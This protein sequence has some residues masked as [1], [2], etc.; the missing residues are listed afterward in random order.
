MAVSRT[1]SGSRMLSVLEQVAAHQPVSLA[2]LTRILRED[3]SAIQRSLMTL[4]D[5]GWI[6]M[7][8]G[9]AG[10]WR[11]TNRIQIVAN[12]ARQ[13]DEMRLR[14]RGVLEALRNETGETALL[15]WLE[16]RRFLII[17]VA[18]S[19]HLVRTAPKVGHEITGETSATLRIILAYMTPEQQEEILERPVTHADRE[20]YCQVRRDGHAINH[21]THTLIPRGQEERGST[22]L[23]APVFDHDG[24]PVGALVISGPSDR[25]YDEQFG[26]L[27]QLVMA[28][29]R[30]LSDGSPRKI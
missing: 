13:N 7:V 26:P 17:D 8:R 23:A 14:A 6:T 10:S 20:I 3:K 15:I 1:K 28:A 5:T 19:Q 22:N 4:A 25:M 21:H 16:H 12:A 11:L 18:E 24:N 27:S 9:S 2:E 30:D 29:A